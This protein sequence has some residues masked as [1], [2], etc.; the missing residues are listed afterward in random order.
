MF[1]Q[2]TAGAIP[3]VISSTRLMSQELLMSLEALH[4]VHDN[5]RVPRHGLLR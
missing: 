5:I 2:L 1:R 3:S 4:R